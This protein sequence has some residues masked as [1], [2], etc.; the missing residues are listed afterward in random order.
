MTTGDCY[1]LSSDWLAKRIPIQAP[2]MS[3][4]GLELSGIT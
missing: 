2:T 3:F 4:S 1:P